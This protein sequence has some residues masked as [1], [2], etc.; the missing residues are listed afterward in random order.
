MRVA[1]WNVNHVLKRLDQ[2]ID[3]LARTAPDVV[4]LQELKIPATQFPTDAFE[5]AGYYSVVVGQRSWN[6][7]ALLARDLEPVQV[8]TALPGDGKDKEARYVEAAINGVLFCCLYAPN[9]NPQPGPKFAYKLA[10]MERMRARAQALWD[11]GQPV[12]LLGDWNVV[13]TDLDIYKPAT[14]RDNALLQPEVR[15]AYAQILAQGWTDALAQVHGKHPPYTFWDYRR[16]RWERD[17]GLRIDHILVSAALHVKAAR[18]DRDERA[19]ES[20][21]DHAPVWAELIPAK[22]GRGR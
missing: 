10:W 19:A 8:L 22:T 7:V 21:S 4:A 11:T 20:P 14:W 16:K 15:E 1:T 12:V 13:P 3:W 9:G 17:A 6:G 18:V 5:R 2:L